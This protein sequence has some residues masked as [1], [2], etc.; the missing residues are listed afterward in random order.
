[1]RVKTAV[2]APRSDFQNE[3]IPMPTPPHQI[4][5]KRATEREAWGIHPRVKT[6]G[7]PPTPF[8][9]KGCGLV[10]VLHSH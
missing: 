8:S 1:M 4:A 5:L 9:V 7:F 3:V 10:A 2:E 6:L